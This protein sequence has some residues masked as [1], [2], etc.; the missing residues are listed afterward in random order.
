MTMPIGFA[1]NTA[2]NFVKAAR[3][4]MAKK[5]YDHFVEKVKAQGVHSL[6]PQVQSTSA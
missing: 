5:L 1:N 6:L 3:P 2:P 4:E